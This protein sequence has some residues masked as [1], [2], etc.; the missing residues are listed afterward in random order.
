MK[1]LKAIFLSLV[2][3]AAVVSASTAQKEQ[4]DPDPA[5]A[6]AIIREAIKARGGDAYARVSN[7]VS[8][9]Q[10][11]RFEK[12]ISLLPQSFTDY[13]VYPDRERTDFGKGDT[14]FV[15]ANTG[16]TGW[17]YDASQKA[18][19]DQTDEQIKS[20]QQSIRYDLDNL[21][22]R[23]WQEPGAKLVY[24]GRREAW[25]NTFSEAVRI[26]FADG[27]SATLHFDKSTKLPLMTEYKTVA[28]EATT[29]NQA[30]FF[31]WVNFGGI[32]YPTIQDFYRNG[33][34]TG[35]AAFD[36]VS[37]NANI[38]EKIFAKPSNVKEVK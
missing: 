6:E 27:A 24:L 10:F 21:L 14:K 29:D 19:R 5:R 22:R 4:D 20:F 12:G 13:V 25:R 7:T 35:R 18:I 33:V 32:M 16:N 26:D 15:Q 1:S 9:G 17:I 3:L 36:E 38:P 28:G 23:A 34:Q 8:Q 2:A 31:R 37:F 11:T 30:R